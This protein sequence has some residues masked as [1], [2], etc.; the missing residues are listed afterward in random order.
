MIGQQDN[1][2]IDWLNYKLIWIH[3][4]DATGKSEKV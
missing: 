2:Q 4:Q 3:I 1:G